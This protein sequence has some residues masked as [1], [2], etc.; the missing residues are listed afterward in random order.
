PVMFDSLSPLGI[1]A[2]KPVLRGEIGQPFHPARFGTS[3]DIARSRHRS[4]VRTG[5]A[6]AHPV[7][8]GILKVIAEA[9]ESVGA[10]FHGDPPRSAETVVARAAASR[11]NKSE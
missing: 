1:G 3:R 4:G 9:R 10:R 6:L 8:V 2:H 11:G 5:L 7:V